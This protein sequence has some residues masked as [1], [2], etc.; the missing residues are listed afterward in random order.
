MPERYAA[1]SSA[2]SSLRLNCS[3]SDAESDFAARSCS[4]ASRAPSRSASRQGLTLVH[5]PAQRKRFVWDEGY[6]MSSL[7]WVLVRV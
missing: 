5:F 1:A 6:F 3:V 4:E 7:R 2:F